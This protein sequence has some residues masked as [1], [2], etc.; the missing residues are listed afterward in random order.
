MESYMCLQRLANLLGNNESLVEILSTKGII[1]GGS[2]VYALLPDVNIDTVGD[3][4][5]FVDTVEIFKELLDFLQELPIEKKYYSYLDDPNSEISIV[6]I[7]L[8]D[9][10]VPIQIIMSDKSDPMELI[11]SFD[12]D[13]VECAFFQGKIY[14]TVNCQ[15][16]HQTRVVD[17]FRLLRS[18]RLL[19]ANKKGFKVPILMLEDDPKRIADEVN[20]DMLQ[21][22]R[23]VKMNTYIPEGQA[24][25]SLRDLRIVGLQERTIEKCITRGYQNKNIN[26]YYFM[27]KCLDEEIVLKRSI[28]CKVN[29]KNIWKHGNI[30]INGSVGTLILNEVPIAL[31]GIST[32]KVLNEAVEN[33][34]DLSTIQGEYYITISI[35]SYLQPNAFNKGKDISNA[36]YKATVHSLQPIGNFPNST[37]IKFSSSFDLSGNKDKILD[38]YKQ[39]SNINIPYICLRKIMA[40]S[41]GLSEKIFNYYIFP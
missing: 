15:I 29:I 30:Y 32:F 33:I 38:L 1:A 41:L 21:Q 17:K 40:F 34:E 28:T 9:A 2:M 13:Y 26:F 7:K 35:Y 8:E 31:Q 39:L 14:Q 12:L 27:T 18:V 4:D 22:Y 37:T 5:V 19:K 3:I 6:S 36:E 20:L 10:K 16:A 11:N 24:T 25:Q 23:I